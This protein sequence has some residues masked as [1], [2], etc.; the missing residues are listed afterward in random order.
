MNETTYN[1]IR[2]LRK[3]MF[4]MQFNMNGADSDTLMEAILVLKRNQFNEEL[5][6]VKLSTTE[7]RGE[8]PRQYVEVTETEKEVLEALHNEMPHAQVGWA[9]SNIE[10]VGKLIQKTK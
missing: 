4:K 5:G 8:E 7:E 6:E 9:D 2:T 10:V 3:T 1:T